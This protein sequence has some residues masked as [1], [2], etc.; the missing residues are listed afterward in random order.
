M[1]FEVPIKV[2][3][4]GTSVIFVVFFNHLCVLYEDLLYYVRH[5]NRTKN[6]SVGHDY[7]LM[8]VCCKNNSLNSNSAVTGLLS[9]KKVA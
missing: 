1:T 9:I 3:S 6:G 2:T 5:C 7:L 8:G 4:L